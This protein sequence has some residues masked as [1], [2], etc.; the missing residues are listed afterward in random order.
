MAAALTDAKRRVLDRLKRVEG[1]TAAELAARLG[2]TEAA[3]RQHLDALEQNGL[4]TGRDRPASGRGR[5]PVVWSL[6]PVAGELFPDRHD[7]ITV[8]LIDATRAALGEDGLTRVIEA[9]TAAQ[10]ASYRE[11]VPG[12]DEAPL[13]RRLD[14]LA[15]RRTAEGYMAE[16][17]RERDGWLLVEHHCPVCVAAESCTGLCRAELDLFRETL[18]PDVEVER[19]QHLL[20]GD[21]R[22]AYVVRPR[23]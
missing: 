8:E 19:T 9:R 6:T 17:S 23:D 10:L 1:A 5:P 11:D 3:V 21:S 16:V 2:L 13:R 20:S 15:R 14:A 7:N 22:C 18:G 4:V 12:P